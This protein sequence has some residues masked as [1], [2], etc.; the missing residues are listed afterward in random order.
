[1]RRTAKTLTQDESSG[2]FDYLNGEFEMVRLKPSLS[3]WGTSF[4]HCATID[5]VYKHL[6]G[7]HSLLIS[8]YGPRQ[9]KRKRKIFH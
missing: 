5:E 3:D 2:T 9:P 7:Y 8:K 1:M 4:R 6:V